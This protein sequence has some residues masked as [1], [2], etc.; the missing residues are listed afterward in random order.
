MCN[1]LD[2]IPDDTN[3]TDTSPWTREDTCE[4]VNVGSAVSG[5][6]EILRS[7]GVQC[8]E[9]LQWY[10]DHVVGVERVHRVS[11][12]VSRNKGELIVRIIVKTIVTLSQYHIATNNPKF[13][14]EHI[15]CIWK[16]FI[17]D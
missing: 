7:H 8:H 5:Q 4:G 14:S 15:P 11:N 9:I 1:E 13:L 6:W 12:T 17:V 10:G 2:I 3:N 16:H